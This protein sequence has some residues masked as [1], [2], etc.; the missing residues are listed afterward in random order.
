M[1]AGRGTPIALTTPDK[2]RGELFHH[3]PEFLPGGTAVL[4]TIISAAG[5]DHQIAA[6]DLKTGARKV[7]VSG[8]TGPQ[9][10]PGGYLIYGAEGTLRAVRFDPARLAVLGD[11]VAVLEG[12]LTK[13]QGGVDFS[14][15]AEG[16][17][18]YVSDAGNALRRRLVWVDR[19]GKTED[20][21]L[22]PRTYAIPRI[23]PDGTRVALDIRDQERDIWI[24]DFA[25]HT[26]NRLTTYP[27]NDGNP[28]WTPDGRR[29]IFNSAREGPT[30]L[31]WQAADG[32]GSAERLA[33]NQGGQ[34]AS[35]IT[36][37]GTGVLFREDSTSGGQNVMMLDLV[38]PRRVKAPVSTKF[39]ERNPALSPDGK[40]LAYESNESGTFEIYVRPFPDV[41]GGLWPVS[42]GGGVQPAWTPDGTELFYVRPD[43]RLMRVPVHTGAT[44]EV[45]PPHVVIDRPLD[46]TLA[47]PRAYDVSPDG[48]RFLIAEAVTPSEA[49]LT[50][51]I[52]VVL[53]LHEELK[54]LL[55][56]RYSQGHLLFLR[57][58][59]LVAHPFDPDRL[60][61][62]GEPFPLTEDVQTD[63]VPR[64]Y[65][66]FSVSTNGRAEPIFGGSNTGERTSADVFTGRALDRV[67][68]ER[69]GSV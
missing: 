42:S 28:V 68:I 65:A 48:Q 30:N 61:V 56:V 35:S 59:T 7:L 5:A 6:L 13:T 27:G 47:T 11:P 69:V 9:F 4:F 12:V 43:G 55:P 51:G 64:V 39:H 24:W 17:L 54:R 29:I 2:A 19:Q 36:P 46:R 37:D 20:L 41:D 33:E 31:Y 1:S 25:R 44:F 3:W 34:V 18:A 67:S 8:G 15:S 22:P 38:P 58:A 49:A 57:D 14:M 40:W 10:V 26:L 32:T 21:D 60:V 66:H 63:G 53:N 52:A 62:T 50:A 45:G 16:T 23:S